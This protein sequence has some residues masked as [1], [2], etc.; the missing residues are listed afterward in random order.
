MT[1]RRK[2]ISS[3]RAARRRELSRAGVDRGLRWT[4]PDGVHLTLKFLGETSSRL[5]PAIERRLVESLAGQRRFPLEL[6]GLGVFPGARSPRVIWVGLGGDLDA[7]AA[8]Q[9]Q[10]EEAMSP[11][12]FAPERRPFSPHLTLARLND[13]GAP[14]ERQA[15]GEIVAGQ[16]WRW[17]G[18]FEATVVSLVRSELGRGGAR[19]TQ[20]LA[21][22]L[23]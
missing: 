17:S 18:R 2:G 4:A 7:L 11:L 8:A 5:L 3:R 19:Y 14:L 10:V 13:W 16:K 1:F 21:V 9:R 20:L 22:P 23:T 6:S 15:I 12:G